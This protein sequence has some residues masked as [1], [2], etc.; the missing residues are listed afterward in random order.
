MHRACNCILYWWGTTRCIQLCKLGPSLKW[1]PLT[2]LFS[3]LFS[4]AT[5]AMKFNPSPQ[6]PALQ[7]VGNVEEGG[8]ADLA[9]LKTGDFIIEVKIGIGTLFW[10]WVCKNYEHR[11]LEIPVLSHFLVFDC[12]ECPHLCAFGSLSNLCHLLNYSHS[13]GSWLALS[14]A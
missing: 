2:M 7:Y 12:W 14:T 5:K 1:L 6:V 13:N 9:G 10:N 4:L 3:S 8:A 11:K